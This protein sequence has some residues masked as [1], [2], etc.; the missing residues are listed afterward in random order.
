MVVQG[1]RE[2]GGGRGQAGPPAPPPP[3]PPRRGRQ[4]PPPPPPPRHFV[5]QKFSFHAKSENI[6]LLHVNNMW[7]FSL[8][9]EQDISDKK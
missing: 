1:R 3:P 6:K 5:E 9:I 4:P 7:D 8:F 2:R